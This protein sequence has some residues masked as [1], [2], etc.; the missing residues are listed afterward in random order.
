MSPPE[1][2]SA[3]PADFQAV[4]EQLPT[5]DNLEVQREVAALLK[6]LPDL[7]VHP[8]AQ[9]L[10]ISFWSAF[11]AFGLTRPRRSWQSSSVR[12]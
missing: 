7:A 6:T 3:Q 1:G 11:E 5:A 10:H 9:Y 2:L 12:I 8:D 4:V